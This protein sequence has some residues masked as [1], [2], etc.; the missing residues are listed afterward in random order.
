MKKKSVIV[1]GTIAIDNVKTPSAEASNLLGGSAAYASLATSFY[2]D[3][4]NLVGIIGHDYPQEHLDMLSSHGVNLA[5]VERS[6]SA[7][8]TWS[9]EYMENMNDRETHAVALNVLEGWE[10]KVPSEISESQIVVLANMSPENQLQMLEGC[11]SAERYVIADTMDLWIAIATEK[12]HEVLEKIDLLVIN[13]SEA[14]EFAQTSNLVL[15]GERLLAKGPE[16]VIIKLGEFGA[17]LFAKGG[18]VFRCPA[19]PLR[20][21]ADPTGAGDSFLGGM[22]GYLASLDSVAFSFDDLRQAMV[23]GTVAAS[24]TCEAFSTQKLQSIER[25]DLDARM[26]KLKAI[27]TW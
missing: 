27:S 24:Y 26:E 16:H 18:E 21:V 6:D 2:H 25:A 15:A 22:A 19:W 11:E 13:E 10:V 7:S 20:E 8:F 5:G 1:G 4:V 14:R 17:M 12:L 9:G 23:R 3:S